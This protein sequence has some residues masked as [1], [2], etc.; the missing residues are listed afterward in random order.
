M[1][2]LKA[3]FNELVRFETELWNIVDARLR[4]TFDL[5]LTHLEHM[6]VIDRRG[7]CRVQDIAA[8]LVI[9]VGGTSKLVDR[10]EASGHCRRE[11]NPDDRRSSIIR[12]TTSGKTLLTD[13]NAVLEEELRRHIDTPLSKQE[14]SAFVTTLQK[15]RTTTSS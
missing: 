5:P 13:A 3:L 10:L 15:L 9:T 7:G 12:L 1:N 11:A 14:I 8:D 6:Q 2:D 4:S